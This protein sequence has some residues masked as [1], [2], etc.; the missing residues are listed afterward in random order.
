M[1][2]L[3]YGQPFVDPSLIVIF[4]ATGAIA[5]G[6]INPR[7]GNMNRPD[8][9]KT[10]VNGVNKIVDGLFVPAVKYAD[11]AVSEQRIALPPCSKRAYIVA[12]DEDINVARRMYSGESRVAENGCNRSP[13]RL[14]ALN[15]M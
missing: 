11:L 14:H 7:Q 10:F 3:P 9:W 13:A 6:Q 15:P 8:E 5:V 12:D 1:N 4:G 2:F